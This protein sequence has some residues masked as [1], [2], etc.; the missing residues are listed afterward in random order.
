ME[1]CMTNK[2]IDINRVMKNVKATLEFEGLI[3]SE[4]ANETNEKMLTGEIS[5]DE[6]REMILTYHDIAVK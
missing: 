2:V 6:A 1:G 5:G 4:F 3:P